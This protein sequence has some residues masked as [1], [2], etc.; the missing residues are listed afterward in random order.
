MP[1]IIGIN[2]K[3]MVIGML[4]FT[5]KKRKVFTRVIAY[6]SEMPKNKY[7]IH[8]FRVTNYFLKIVARRIKIALFFPAGAAVCTFKYSAFIF[9]SF[10]NAIK[11]V[12]VWGDKIQPNSPQSAA[13]Y[14]FHLLK[15]S[16]SITV[17]L[18]ICGGYG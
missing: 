3:S 15:P 1:C 12:R 10:H 14:S 7:L 18:L 9:R 4:I 13:R 17:V 8:I 11:Y 5:A 2:P 16:G 6:I